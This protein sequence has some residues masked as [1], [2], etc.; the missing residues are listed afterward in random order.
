[1]W[2]EFVFEVGGVCED[3]EVVVGVEIICFFVVEGGVEIDWVG[4]VV[5]GDGG[6]EC[7]ERFGMCLYGVVGGGGVGGGGFEENYVVDG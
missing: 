2:C 6:V 1:M 4:L 7:I 5:V 3:F